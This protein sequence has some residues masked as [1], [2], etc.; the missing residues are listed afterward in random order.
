MVRD[1]VGADAPTNFIWGICTGEGEKHVGVQNKQ[2]L[3][4]DEH[5]VFVSQQTTAR[6]DIDD[7]EISGFG[8]AGRCRPDGLTIFYGDVHRRG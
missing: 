8:I 6:P 3:W 5:L 2:L 4:I 7:F 1:G